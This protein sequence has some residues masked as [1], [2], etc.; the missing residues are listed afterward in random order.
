M[1]YKCFFLLFILIKIFSLS[2]Y[3][4]DSPLN[5]T[6]DGF[7]EGLSHLVLNGT[8]VSDDGHSSVALLRD[9]RNRQNII[10][11][12]GDTIS[13][14]KLVRILGNRIDFQ[15]NKKTF[16]LFLGRSGFIQADEEEVLLPDKENVIETITKTPEAKKD[17]V[18]KKEYLRSYIVKR[19][20]DDWKMILQQIVFSPHIVEGRTKGFKLT[21]IPEGSFLSEMGIKSDDIILKLNNEELVDISSF[22]T[23]IDKYKSDDRVE[24]TI[25]RS[26]ESVRYLYL[27]K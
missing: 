22:S 8:I 27:L 15:S 26:G 7:G 12:I 9:D 16:Q 23:L 6:Q 14:F 1:R 3:S 2:T 19:I 18:I 17:S 13:H 21:K 20:L 11:S 24:M 10:L 25:E 5:S 4:F